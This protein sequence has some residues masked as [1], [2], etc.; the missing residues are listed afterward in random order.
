[1]CIRDSIWSCLTSSNHEIHEIPS[2]DKTCP[3]AGLRAQ[4]F[5][6]HALHTEP[7]LIPK[8]CYPSPSSRS[9]S[10]IL[11][12]SCLKVRLAISTFGRRSHVSSQAR[13]I[14]LRANALPM[15]RIIVAPS[16]YTPT[17]PLPTGS[18]LS[19]SPGRVALSPPEFCWKCYW[20]CVAQRAAPCRV[21]PR[22]AAVQLAEMETRM[23]LIMRSHT[24]EDAYQ[25]MHVKGDWI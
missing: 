14:T 8:D 24:C 12:I 4:H 20:Q 21:A 6:E 10:W 1:M 18:E 25:P 19:K 22:R 7:H 5:N 16:V 23:Q 13:I 15:W 9:D 3:P 17:H 11:S 2:S